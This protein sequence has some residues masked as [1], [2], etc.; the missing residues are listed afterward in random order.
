M[1]RYIEEKDL[2]FNDF[3]KTT[4]QHRYLHEGETIA[5]R[6]NAVVDTFCTNEDHKKRFAGY[7]AKQWVMPATPILS[8]GGAKKGLPISCFLN[9]AQDS[10][11][12]IVDLWN[13]NVWL[14]SSGGGIGSYWGNLRSIGEKIDSVGSTCGV[15]PFIVVQDSL[16]LAISQGSLRR[17]STALYLPVWHPEIEEFIDIRRPTGGDPNR[18]A[19]NIN[20]AVVITDDFMHAVEKGEQYNLVSPKDG[21]ICK[22]VD[23]RELWIRILTA[24]IETGEPYILYIDNVNKLRPEGYKKNNLFVKT[25]NLCSEI[26]LHTGKDHRGLERTAICCLTSVN[27]EYYD[28][29][30]NEELF[31]PDVM[32]FLDN[33]LNYFINKAP[34][35]K[36]KNAIY[37]AMRERSV[38]LSAMGFHSYLQSKM[39]AFGSEE[40]REINKEIFSFLDSKS[41]ESSIALAKK[42]GACPD[43]AEHGIEERFMH[44]TAVVPNAST[45]IIANNVSPGIEPIMAN[46]YTQKT[47]SGSFTIVNKYLKKLLDNM[48]IDHKKVW[49][50]IT[51]N[52]GSV[53]HLDC[54]TAHQKEVFKTAFEIDQKW[55]IDLS[56]DRTPY[57]CQGQSLNLFLPADVE[58]T[59]LHRIHFSA[60]KKGLKSLYYQRSKVMNR[61]ENINHNVEPIVNQ[62][63]ETT[64]KNDNGKKKAKET[65]KKNELHKAEVTELICDI[66]NECESCS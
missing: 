55:L 3:A 46:T 36:M 49:E 44:R 19:L 27:L 61:A 8:N 51:I 33:V 47:L 15:I 37:S 50:S 43:N 40:A 12:G 52:T 62:Q 38:G 6:L 53:Q 11:Q 59:E 31:I 66:S 4:L 30:R 29:W 20:N 2:F 17:G 16:S 25:S 65:K 21:V 45:S 28:D 9:E 13:E 57:V 60:W 22:T 34:A 58:K 41:L 5:D 26:M 10:L 23:A 42:R 1:V 18:K 24:R 54:L 56:A 35:D 64:A 32:E 48:D 39:I 63:A 7:L 14:A